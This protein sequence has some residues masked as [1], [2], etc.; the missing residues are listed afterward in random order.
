MLSERHMI[1]KYIY[2]EKLHIH[3]RPLKALVNIYMKKGRGA[4]PWAGHVCERTIKHNIL[5][6]NSEMSM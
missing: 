3:H 1:L 4:P 5:S 2:G 6:T